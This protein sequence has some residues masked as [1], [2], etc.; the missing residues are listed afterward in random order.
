VAQVQLKRDFP[1][2]KHKQQ[3]TQQAVLRRVGNH[4]HERMALDV[5]VG[6]VKQK[7]L[8]DSGAFLFVFIHMETFVYIK[9]PPQTW[10]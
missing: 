2:F 9:K 8:R 10:R 4:V 5:V 6:V 3:R 1:P 7:S